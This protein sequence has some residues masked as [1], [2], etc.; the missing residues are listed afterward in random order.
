MRNFFL[1]V[2]LV[3]QI[4]ETYA[5]NLDI[6]AAGFLSALKS[7]DAGLIQEK[8]DLLAE[9][10]KKSEQLPFKDQIVREIPIVLRYLELKERLADNTFLPEKIIGFLLNAAPSELLIVKALFN[11]PISKQSKSSR[12]SMYLLDSVRLHWEF[13][14]SK[15]KSKDRSQRLLSLRILLKGEFIDRE[16]AIMILGHELIGE[17][18]IL[19]HDFENDERGIFFDILKN[20]GSDAKIFA[21]IL[22]DYVSA[23]ATVPP[24]FP[25]PKVAIS[26]FLDGLG[27]ISKNDP[28]TVRRL[29]EL[30]A[31][32]ASR[33]DRRDV[34]E[35][36]ERRLDEWKG[37][38]SDVTSAQQKLDD[39][40]QLLERYSDMAKDQI[41]QDLPNLVIITAETIAKL[42]AAE[43]TLYIQKIRKVAGLK[44]FDA[45][46]K[47]LLK[48]PGS[49]IK[50][51]E[52]G[53][54]CGNQ[55]K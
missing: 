21:N 35:M 52:N 26:L 18:E 23:L 30:N 25:I 5:S 29:E 27:N 10:Y 15:L 44:F 42:P 19:L 50:R 16:Q 6:L 40:I 54:D 36:I 45:I 7:K 55:F 49:G 3:T 32:L 22:L 43:H 31:Q 39:F 20:L 47:Q 33:V 28:T 37:G 9:V 14:V 13:F 8:V 51:S 2:I 1:T 48:N 38:T 53:R 12:L 4:S 41:P 17:N 46:S 24:H 11:S 34:S